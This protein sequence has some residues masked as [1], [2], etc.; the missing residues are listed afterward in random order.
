MALLDVSSLLHDPDFVDGFLVKRRVQVVDT[1]GRMVASEVPIPAL[2]GVVTMTS[3]SDLDR[4]PDYQVNT[5]SITVVCKFA[6][7]GETTNHQPD[8]VVWRGDNYVV[9]HVD[10][11][12]QFGAGFFQAECESMDKTDEALE[13]GA[14]GGQ[15]LFNVAANSAFFILG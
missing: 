6:L 9:R 3:P 11:Y 10:L 8:I 12:P 5:R 14:R 13:P 15:L 2:I 4:G 1:H 7:R